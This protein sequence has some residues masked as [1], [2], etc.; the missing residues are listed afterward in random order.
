MNSEQS[1]PEPSDTRQAE[2]DTWAAPA[3]S[4]SDNLDMD[5]ESR[6]LIEQMLAE[7]EYF[8]GRDTISTL[9]QQSAPKKKRKSPK[10]KDYDFEHDAST[11]TSSAFAKRSRKEGL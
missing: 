8:Y 2:Q 9:K 11:S 1:Q 5:D 3:P 6:K 4:A 7:E 10:D